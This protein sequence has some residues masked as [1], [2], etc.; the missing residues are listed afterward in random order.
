MPHSPALRHSSLAHCIF[1]IVFALAVAISPP[2]AIDAGD[3]LRGG[4]TFGA[5]P[6]PNKTGG[7]V[8]PVTSGG[9]TSGQDALA[10]TTQA[11]QAVRAMQATAHD[12]AI[13]GA[14]NLGLDPNHPGFVL[15]NVPNGLVVGGL[16]VAPGVPAKLSAPAP[17]EDSSL[18]QGAN[19]PTQTVSDGQTRVNIKQTAQQA[20][21][22][23]ETFN[24]GKQTTVNFDQTAGGSNASEWIAF[25]TIADPSGRPSQILGSI[26][27]VGQVYLLNQNGIIF[28]G[29]SQVNV[30]TLTASS[31]PINT[32]L[33]SRGLL[34]NP[35]E[36]FLFSALPIPV[37]PNGGTLP[38]FE[39]PAPPNTPSGLVGDVTVQAGATLTSP[40]TADHVGGRIALLGLNTT[41]NGTI[42]TPD[43]QTI[44]AAGQQV[45][46]TAHPTTDPSLRGLDV[47]V[48]QVSPYGSAATNGGLIDAPRANVTLA[49]QNVSQMGVINS[50]TSVSLNG[51]IDLLAAYNAVVSI[52]PGVS[53]VAVLD[54]TASG[55]LTLGPG[56]V[57]NVLPEVD[58][59]ERI[60]GTQ[61]ALP[62]QVNLQGKAVHFEND[63][64][65]VAPNAEVKVG[66]GSWLPFNN[67]YS[68]F[69]TDGQIYLET[70]AM[71]DVSGSAAVTA[72][73]SENII[74]VQLRG[75]E[76]A[77]YPLQRD[78]ALRGQTI[79]IDIRQTGTYN[80][81]PYVGTPLAD[82][83]GYVALV[84]RTVGELTTAGG[85]VSLT[86]GDSVV[87]QPGAA[88]N[89]SGGW[90]DYT[91]DVVQTTRV[92]SGGRIFDISQA[93]P[94]RIY[95]GIYGGGVESHPKWGISET[96]TNPLASAGQYEDGYLQGGNGG[97]LTISASSMALDGQFLGTTIVGPRQRVTPP[98]LSTLSLAFESRLASNPNLFIS[99][100]PP[101][102]T[103]SNRGIQEPAN[104]FALDNNLPLPLREDRQ[105]EVILSPTL[106]T[107]SGFGSLSITNSDGDVTLPANVSLTTPAGGSLTISAANLDLEGDI[108]APGGALI[109]NVYDFSPYEFA[110]LGET[111]GATSPPADP[112]RGHF[113]LGAG[114]FLNATGMLADDR[115]GIFAPETFPLVTTGG[116]V[117]IKS[118]DADLRAGSRIDVSG[119]GEV[120]SAN[121]ASYGNGGSIVIQAGKDLEVSALLG[122]ELTLDAVLSGYGG[123]NLGGSL[124]IQ[125]PAVQIGGQTSDANTLLLDPEFFSHGG[126]GSFTLTGLGAPTETM[127][128]YLPAVTIAPG[129]VIQ[130]IALSQFVD[131][132]IAPADGLVLTQTLLPQALRTPVSLAFKAPG[133]TD[134]F[135]NTLIV[136]GDFLMEKGSSIVT[137][138]KASVTIS[139]NTAAV[140]GSITAPAGVISVTGGSNSSN[141]FFQKSGVPLATVDLGPESRLSTAG[142]TLLTPNSLGFRTGSVLDGGTITLSGNIV[143]EG[144]SI[145]DVSGATDSLDV[146]PGFSGAPVPTDPTAPLFVR[147][148]IDSNGG[149]LLFAGGQEVFTDATLIGNAGG[150]SAVGGALTIFSGRFVDPAIAEEPTPLDVN[151]EV[152]QAGPSIPVSFY[153]GDETAIGN[154]VIDA[155]GQAIPGLGHFV[156]ASFNRSG[157]ASLTLKDTVGFVG[158]V[159]INAGGSLTVGTGGV[160]YADG[161][162]HLNGSSVILGQP[163]LPPVAPEDQVAPFFVNNSP[164]YFSPTHG[165]GVLNVSGSLIEIGNLS[166]QNIGTANLT[167]T[168]GDIRGD[169]TFDVA[170]NISL[171]AGQIYPLTEV[172]F[173]IAAFDYDLDGVMQNGAVKI[174]PAG[175][176]FLPLSAGGTLNIFANTISQGGVLRAPIGS[177]NIG[178]SDFSNEAVDPISNL[179]FTSTDRLIL[180]PT[181]VASASAVDPTTGQALIIPY[182]TDSNGTSWIDPAGIDITAG[183]GPVKRVTV[184]AT[185]VVDEAG[186]TVDLRGGGDLFAYR[187]VPGLGG[188]VDILG[189]PTSYAIVPGYGANYAPIDPGYANSSLASG[190]Q[191]YLNASAALPAGVYT[192]LPA[193]YALLPGAVLVTAQSTTPNDAVLRLDGSSLVS[194]YRFNA[195]TGQPQKQPLLTA[196]EVAPQSVVQ[197]RAEYDSFSANDFLR[198]GALA[199]DA[200]VPRLPIDSGQLV[201]AATGA[202]SVSGNV[203]A[204]APEGGRGGLVDINTPDDILIA[205][206]GAVAPLG[207]LMLDAAELS[208]F[209]S[210]SLLIGGLRQNTPAG[211][212][213]SVSSNNIV[214]NNVDSPL[215]GSGIVL[216]AKNSITLTAGSVVEQSTGAATATADT[217]ILGDDALP[218]SGNGVILR[219]SSDSTAAISR[220]GVDGSTS[221][222]LTVA[223]GAMIQGAG[224]ILDSTAATSLDPTAILSG[225]SIALDSGQISIQLDDPGSLQPTT[226]LVLSG[227]ALQSLQASARA[228]SLLSY[229]S[230]DIYGTGQVGSSSVASLALHAGQIRSFNNGGGDVTFAAQDISLD[231][232][233]NGQAV[234]SLE[235]T[236]GTLTFAGNTIHLGSGTLEI[237]QFANTALLADGGVLFA[238]GGTLNSQGNLNLVAPVITGS[239]AAGYTLSTAGALNFEAPADPSLATVSGGLGASLTLVGASVVENG[240]IDLPSGN[241]IIQANGALPGS[242][243]MIGGHLDVSGTTQTFYD[244]VKYTNGGQIDLRANTG[245]IQVASNAVIT[246]AAPQNGDAGSLIMS[247][248]SGNLIT[249]G[250]LI[251]TGGAGGNFDL[252]IGSLAR[253]ATLDTALDAGGFSQSRTIRVRT[254][255]VLVNG[256]ASARNYN[257]STDE[258]AIT[259]TGIID[260]Y[261]N[262]GG[263]IGLFANGGVTLANGAQL[264]AAAIE[265]DAAGNLGLVDLETRGADGGQ[266]DIQAGSLI[267]LSLGIS[268]GG[269]LHLRAPQNDPATDFAVATIEGQILNPGSIIAEA[270]RIFD[271]SGDG[272]IDAQE[273]FVLGNGLSISNNAP[274]IESRVLG[275]NG[276]M[277]S[278]FHVRPGAEIINSTGDLVLNDDWDLSTYR[279]G[280]RMPV[281]DQLGNV[282]YDQFGN[283]VLAGVEPGILTLRAKD[284]ITFNGALTDGFGDSLGTI[285]FDFFGNVARWTSP[286][287]PV[288][289]DGTP[290]QSWSYRITAGAD[291]M[292]A[293]YRRTAPP[294]L[295]MPA[296]SISLGV[297][298]GSVAFG[299][300]DALT[301]N[302]LAEHYQVIRTGTGD[303]EIS[304]GGDIKLQNQFATIYTAGAQVADSTMGGTFDLPQLDASGGEMALGAVQESPAYPA[305][306]SGGGG[307]VTITAGGDILHIAMDNTGN[308]IADSERQLPNNWLYRRG[309]VDPATGDF[310]VA[311]YGDVASTSWWVDFSNFF[312]GVG[313]LGGGNVTMT[314]G[315]DI[316]NVDAVVPTNARL[317]NNSLNAGDPVE[318]GG[319]NLVLQAGHD[320]DGG[321]YYVERG[322]GNL[323]A[324]NTI[325]TNN[326]RS[327]SLTTLTDEEP[328]PEETWLP[329]TLFLGKG[330]FTVESTGDLTLGPVANP[331][332]LA[333]GYS[334]T[335]WYKTYFSTYAATDAVNV[336]SLTGTVTL[337]ESATLPTKVSPDPLLSVW[338]QNVLLLQLNLVTPSYYQPWL[339]LDETEVSAFGTVTALQPATLRAT[340]FSGD[341]NFVGQL[342]LSPSATGTIDLAASGA[343]N[344]L[345][346]S[347]VVDLPNIPDPQ[348]A[349]NS[350]YINLSDADPA[351]IPGIASPFAF[352]TIAGTSPTAVNSL[353]NTL[354]SV[355]KLFQ[356]S[357]S[358]SGVQAV[359]QTK[360]ALHAAGVLHRADPDPIHLYANDGNI[361]GFTL[362][363]AKAAKITAG[364]DLTDVSLY[365][366]NTDESDITAVAAGR[367]IVAYDPTSPLRAAALAPGN[368][369]NDAPQAGD[370]QIS[371]P[372]EL[373]VLA[374]RNLDLGIGPNNVAGTGVGMTSIGNARNPFLAFAGAEIVAAAGIGPA[375]SLAGSQL[376]FEGLSNL[377]LNPE[378]AADS[379]AR[380]LPQLAPLLGLKDQSNAVIW[381]AFEELPTEQQDLLATKIFYL[382][383]RDAA[384]D[385]TDPGAAG[386]GTYDAG[387]TAIATLFPK[388]APEGNISLP[389]R[390]IKTASGGD[391]SLLAPAG[392]LTVGFASAAPAADQGILTEDGG[393]IGIFTDDSVAV[394]TSRIFTLRG[395]NEIIWSTTGDIAA[396]ASSKTVQSAP[397]TRVLIDPQSGDVKTD[398][399]GLATGGGIGV[400]DTVA[401]VPPGDVD[402]IAPAGT[403]DAGDAGIR[404]S[405]NLNISAVEVLNAGNISVAGTSAGVPTIATPNLAGL[406]AA[407]NAVGASTNTAEA[408]AR[409][410]GPQP[411]QTILPSIV[412]V[413]VLGYGNGE[414]Q[415]EEE[416]RR[417]GRG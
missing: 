5:A 225:D 248:V 357:G 84:D 263:I 367:D 329:T 223:T 377:F 303:I 29:S 35:D 155:D 372:G 246:V 374:G 235:A 186:A 156:A 269:T 267:N 181:A 321:V 124:T 324:G 291:F 67:R 195:F 151:I 382:V 1:R 318:L 104:A 175:D 73:V 398:L 257:L 380:Y 82:T 143:A 185:T 47:F 106:F 315:H 163:F 241:L 371:G 417:R 122:G 76:L 351:S 18:W 97:S 68:F 41:N 337:R 190:D 110:I 345:S 109:F 210:E 39:P 70:G 95:Q 4:A 323:T 211:T 411:E 383:L 52:P 25:N 239:T 402:L 379:G 75:S 134:N 45:A 273:A 204:Q 256:H 400:L 36:Q 24:V 198:N 407:S 71:I 34:N 220:K 116:S 78:G 370:I 236:R 327:P 169:G 129:T 322:Q 53:P 14:A 57:T 148:R 192:L 252:D 92:V 164:F 409:Q 312:E 375:S 272:S 26:D 196:F 396:G 333:G 48:G 254:G 342:I 188:T 221:P 350:G 397:P 348:N 191:I 338:Q 173:N 265:P 94:D 416:R 412:T 381:S 360:Q 120:D 234:P 288:F 40:S 378:T 63:A 332:L 271:A 127:D 353:G 6:G 200:A 365:I 247:A 214:V 142:V 295:N 187:F 32:N 339:R 227:L 216:A 56:S 93:T 359:L 286:L 354:A 282:L 231:N 101:A 389:S 199:N 16:Q 408:A 325:H 306:Y 89:V 205:G 238:G 347:G 294:V 87:I 242:D 279:G 130:P 177:V 290:Q 403:V 207:S 9:N 139:G 356:E 262:N 309:Y 264:N 240:D 174:A 217:L 304:A 37:L 289:A 30:H 343:I 21:L 172:T 23:W 117:T 395:G 50:S 298:G 302:A 86:A 390:E 308:V 147:T 15:P 335:F 28:G 376:D 301:G 161:N 157:F 237:D 224:I 121:I 144:G 8:P 260:A 138:P 114:A 171:T 344:G 280:D 287:L 133:V 10:R 118:Y 368:V 399:A 326:T 203:L 270:Y 31:L 283:P 352:Q 197:A 66:A 277:A 212:E 261:S 278:I 369:L 320:I 159:T 274:A 58:S 206:P 170:G 346:Q 160:V 385:R 64:F 414:D 111:P 349:F 415:S 136:R 387:Y 293:D 285:P 126:F 229:S 361:S 250:T 112:A 230:L 215:S 153:P 135:T 51:R 22:N 340:A 209:D 38:A 123:G 99:N 102:I 54:S 165:S 145:I 245:N 2:Q 201:L 363:S 69:A 55:L 393:N 154:A 113:T 152:T 162:V 180:A 276:F 85:S 208:T 406:T 281:V 233:A 96:R 81:I 219:V 259:V 103:F 105:S 98:G 384:R 12:A 27:A 228:L 178:S 268:P 91:G 253:T 128:N 132:N 299:G 314:A 150:Q 13:R 413:E 341:L 386:F 168:N 107:S 140:L 300:F 194:G 119:G 358:T 193:R 305:Q 176:R 183:G 243:L 65:L 392:G 19:L 7:A 232:S 3:I 244:L 218:G 189:S 90:I 184:T 182:G 166:L 331:F 115:S 131:P 83:S 366:Q 317:S 373:E 108:T 266:I 388:I 146:L 401:G 297:F 202:L 59:T 167:A 74:P 44:L 319:G 313:A 292:A 311:K 149:S 141:L 391:I 62:S 362:F 46:F 258:G 60:V 20:L 404:V 296:A 179:P 77:N 255:D 222:T 80:G 394:G 17:G 79:M 334:N 61:L 11:V 137:D 328:L 43:G 72:S 226:G 100:L 249:A 275:V 213:V 316:Q 307:N 33:V 125:A 364:K 42:S 330:D 251:G 405:G 310:G 410:G 284:S 49:G 88:V 355:N 158:P 336:S